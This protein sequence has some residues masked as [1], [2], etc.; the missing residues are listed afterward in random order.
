M[1]KINRM[2]LT[3]IVCATAITIISLIAVGAAKVVSDINDKIDAMEVTDKRKDQIYEMSDTLVPGSWDIDGNYVVDIPITNT[4]NFPEYYNTEYYADIA[5]DLGDYYLFFV[6]NT[7]TYNTIVYL[8]DKS[9][10]E[11]RGVSTDFAF[12]LGCERVF[13]DDD[14]KLVLLTASARG[15]RELHILDFE[16]GISLFDDYGKGITSVFYTGETVY[17]SGRNSI[18]DEK[19]NLI[20]T[21]SINPEECIASFAVSE[22]LNTIV[23]YTNNADFISYKKNSEGNYE[24]VLKVLNNAMYTEY[25]NLVLCGDYFYVRETDEYKNN[26][27]F[28]YIEGDT[29]TCLVELRDNILIEETP[30]GTLKINVTTG[31]ID[32]SELKPQVAPISYVFRNPP[33][34]SSRITEQ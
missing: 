4:N 19:E 3:I 13:F 9:T 14:G 5:V 27:A 1:K 33:L 11:L 30:F 20:F 31:E 15:S 10:G 28:G 7:V 16:S 25:K 18:Y 34:T 29:H 12:L 26:L 24:E 8:K 2:W 21:A 22:N 32:L 17:A 23:C 6:K